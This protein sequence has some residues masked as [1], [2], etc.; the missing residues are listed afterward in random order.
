MMH[1]YINE[2]INFYMNCLML[3][4]MSIIINIFL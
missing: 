2:N 1:I 4:K 3:M